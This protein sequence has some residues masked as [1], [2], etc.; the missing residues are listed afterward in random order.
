MTEFFHPL[1]NNNHI[2][3][4]IDKLGNH[5]NQLQNRSTEEIYA[6]IIM[7][8]RELCLNDAEMPLW[9]AVLDEFGFEKNQKF[10]EVLYCTAC[11]AKE[12]LK[13]SNFIN[14]FYIQ[15]NFCADF[16]R[17][18][19]NWIKN[20]DI[21]L[22]MSKVAQGYFL[23]VPSLLTRDYEKVVESL[24]FGVTLAAENN[25][26]EFFD[27]FLG[28][29]HDLATSPASFDDLNLD[30]ESEDSIGIAP[31]DDYTEEAMVLDPFDLGD[32]N[33]D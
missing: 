10:M 4:L 30:L 28:V 16:Q 20:K 14:P 12:A 9:W 7:V 33:L 1:D 11:M 26:T 13:T 8:R 2:V 27:D 15:A 18:Y 25:R 21:N 22:S 24:T 3:E 17:I 31:L 32:F 6:D 23:D 5:F 29:H 19:Q